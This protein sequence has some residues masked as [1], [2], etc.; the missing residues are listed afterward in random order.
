M[1]TGLSRDCAVTAS[2]EIRRDVRGLLR[3]A[4]S[5]GT[6]TISPEGGEALPEYLGRSGLRV[7]HTETLRRLKAESVYR[8]GK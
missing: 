6:K 1:E 4:L 3:V 5:V 8:A 2:L 7:L